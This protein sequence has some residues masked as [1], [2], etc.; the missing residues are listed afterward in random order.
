MPE[1]CDPAG[2]DGIF[3]IASGGVALLNP[4][5]P[6]GKP[7]ACGIASSEICPRWLRFGF[8][9]LHYESM[10]FNHPVVW[11]AGGLFLIALGNLLAG[12]ES[13]GHP[14]TLK[15]LHTAG[16]VIAGMGIV[17]ALLALGTWLAHRPQKRTG[18]PLRRS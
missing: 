3:W 11:A 12:T 13:L 1:F 14:D 7:P 18:Q 15:G 4:R 10:K 8:V 6:S 2:V 17:V 5:L 16:I 9:L